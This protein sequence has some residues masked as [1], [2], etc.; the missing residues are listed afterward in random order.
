MI[1][2]DISGREAVALVQG[3]LPDVKIYSMSGYIGEEDNKWQY[4]VLRKPFNSKELA[5]FLVN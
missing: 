1:L 4:P 5:E 3:Q 2:P